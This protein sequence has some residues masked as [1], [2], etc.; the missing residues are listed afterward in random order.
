MIEAILV[1]AI[2][3]TNGEGMFFKKSTFCSNRDQE[4]SIN[5]EGRATNSASELPILQSPEY[6]DLLEDS[7]NQ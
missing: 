5:K 4:N 1:P 7:D 2:K 3:A 6:S